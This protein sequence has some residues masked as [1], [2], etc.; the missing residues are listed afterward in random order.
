MS[1]LIT[2]GKTAPQMLKSLG[3]T[4]L[5]SQFYQTEPTSAYRL[6]ALETLLMSLHTEPLLGDV[7]Y[8]L[9]T[10]GTHYGSVKNS[11]P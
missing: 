1:R 9:N 8:L 10:T 4:T 5:T 6:E 7:V 3:K 2:L 11:D